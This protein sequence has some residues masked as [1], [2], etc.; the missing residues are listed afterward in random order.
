M[1]WTLRLLGKLELTAPDGAV[2]H[3]TSQRVQLLVALL[4][5]ENGRPVD[6]ARLWALLWEDR[7]EAQARNSLRQAFTA[8]RK[9]CDGP[10]PFPF[11]V[12]AREASADPGLIRTDTRRLSDLAETVSDDCAPPQRYQEFLSGLNLPGAELQA[13]LAQQRQRWREVF[14]RGACNAVAAAERQGNVAEAARRAE[15]LLKADPFNEAAHRALV[16]GLL[17]AGDR[18]GALR[19]FQQCRDLLRSELQ[20][21]PDPETLALHT[22]ILT[23][24]TLTAGPDQPMPPPAMPDREKPSIVVLPFAAHGD[25]G[26]RPQDFADGLTESLTDDLSR[27]HDLHVVA[28]RS[29]LAYRGGA[30]DAADICL[31][32]GVRY[33]LTGSVRIESGRLRVQARMVDGTDGRVVWTERYDRAAADLV[34]VRDELGEVIVA[35]LANTYGGRLRKAWQNSPRAVST[36]GSEAYDCFVRGLDL[37]DRWTAE[38][39]EPGVALLRRAIDIDPGFAKAHAKLSFCEVIAAHEGWSADFEASLDRGYQKARDAIAA[40]DSEP[41]GHWALSYCHLFDGKHDLC[42][43]SIKHALRLNPNDADILADLGL[44]HGCA[45]RPE[46]G[47]GVLRDAMRRNPHFPDWYVLQLVQVEFDARRY[48]DAERTHRRMRI[49]SPLTDLYLAASLAALGRPVEAARVLARAQAEAPDAVARIR[50]DPRRLPYRRPED[51]A[52]FLHYLDLAE[53]G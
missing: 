37:V 1:T 40:D 22:E 29:A 44:F 16:R 33:A 46:L 50:T 13:W 27:F 36:V 19:K 8:L 20:I 45:G 23:A 2:V 41:W 51:R 38:A 18:A 15:T 43:H 31:K 17:E 6:R 25:P 35:T 32:L 12:D 34:H 30:P 28:S 53:A 14:V 5:L 24:I 9:A 21:E 52:H 47:V 4:A 49:S 10:H 7:A 48:A 11:R 26:C 3:L 42:L 39:L